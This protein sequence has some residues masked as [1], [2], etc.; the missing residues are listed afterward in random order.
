[1]TSIPVDPNSQLTVAAVVDFLRTAPLSA[2]D[3][4]A[5]LHALREGMDDLVPPDPA[6][7]P[8][9][10]TARAVPA[11]FVE[12]T[13]N[14]ISTSIVWQQAAAA[15]P[16]ELRTHLAFEEYRPFSEELQTFLAIVDY[17][18]R[19]HHWAAVEKSRTAYHSGKTLGGDEGH[20]IKPHLK[21]M[22]SSLP[23]NQRKTKKPAPE[24]AASPSK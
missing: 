13:I 21:I 12:S 4:L 18:L 19:Y 23:K 9:L 8:R 3:R 15:T 16:K 24:A 6:L 7:N 10:R 14:G 20:I 11:A 1:M 2:E 17:S 5:V 22:S